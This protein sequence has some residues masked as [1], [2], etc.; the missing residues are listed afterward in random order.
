LNF[1]NRIFKISNTS[2]FN[3][4]AFEVF[5]HQ[6]ENIDV[7]RKYVDLCCPTKPTF[8]TV[9]EIPFLPIDF[10]KSQKIIVNNTKEECVFG[11]SGT[12]DTGQ[13]LH[14]VKDLAV[15]EKSFIKGINMFYG[16]I[17]EYCIL[18]LLPSYLERTDSSLI[19]MV[20]HLI[21]VSQCNDSEFYLS[22]FDELYEKIN[23]L[24]GKKQKT[25]LIGISYALLDFAEKYQ[26]D[27]PE[28]IV[29]ETGGMKGKRK[30]MIRE[31]MHAFL[32]KRFG[33]NSIHS[34][35]GMTE[36]LSQAYSKGKGIFYCPPWM[37]VLARDPN[38]P[39][40]V[41]RENKKGCMNIIDLANFNSCSF[42]ATD[43]Y[44]LVNT[45]GS[46]E[47]LGRFDNSDIRG[48]NLMAE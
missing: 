23:F 13:S 31:E 11:S 1:K 42:I 9:E 26:F 37:R 24:Q 18:V 39:R 10:F 3:D 19:F 14:Y 29:M 32:E 8:K 17:S 44:G 4:I 35:Y 40:S 33:V 15:Y 43:D 21:N 41:I 5:N 45:N 6:Y 7:Y 27:F 12:T 48:C 38:D 47:V 28:L 2:E 30:E 20:R 36:L 46:F 22:N 16:K 34:E 25:I